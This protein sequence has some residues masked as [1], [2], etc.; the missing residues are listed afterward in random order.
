MSDGSIDLKHEAR[1][2]VFAEPLET[3]LGLLGIEAPERM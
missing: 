1:A 2:K 3:S